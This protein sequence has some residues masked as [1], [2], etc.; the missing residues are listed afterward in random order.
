MGEHLSLQSSVVGVQL[1]KRFAEEPLWMADAHNLAVILPNAGVLEYAR[2]QR[3]MV[4]H[5]LP[6]R[7]QPVPVGVVGSVVVDEEAADTAEVA[8][9]IVGSRT[10]GRRDLL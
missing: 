1:K 9:A 7:L 5:L 8:G 4:V 6:R 2:V 3:R 10:Y